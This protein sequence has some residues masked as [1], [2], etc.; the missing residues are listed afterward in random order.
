M[1]VVLSTHSTD[2]GSTSRT[3]E[4]WARLLPAQGVE[5]VVTVGGRG[6]LLSALRETGIRARIR[7]IKVQPS[8]AWP[9]PFGL[10]VLRLA[11]TARAA[12]AAMIHVNE[13]DNHPVAAYAAKLAKI[14]IVTHIRFRPGAEY[15]RWLFRAN[16]PDR[17]FFTSETQ[18]RDSAAAVAPV[19]PENRWR[20]LPNGLDFSTFG[21]DNG[22]RERLRATWNLTDDVFALGSACALSSRKRVDYFIRLV[23]RLRKEGI[24]ARGFIAGQPYFPE[25]V[26]VVR[27]LQQLVS[28]LGLQSAVTFLGYVEPS[29]PLYHAWDVCVSTSKYETFGM[30]V[31]EAMGCGC[32]VVTY[33]GGA[34]EE[35]VGDAAIVLPDGDEQ[36]LLDACLSLARAPR[37]RRDLGARGRQRAVA[38]YDIRAIVPRLAREY[39]ELS[40]RDGLEPQRQ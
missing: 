25:D 31:L 15:C 35:V 36:S 28:D 24:D 11:G 2:R 12:G 26:D 37:S 17:L 3:L 30:T 8:K 16:C 13:H 18:M 21:R 27:Q 7:R 29:E 40:D 38:T 10:A 9:V 4:A 1:N 6:P 14:P 22:Q 34:I 23:D 32:P 39:A 33:P 5:P 19:V 20:V